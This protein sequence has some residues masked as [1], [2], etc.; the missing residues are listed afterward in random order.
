MLC[1]HRTQ[2]CR[3][4]HSL[5]TSSHVEQ[6][7]WFTGPAF[8]ARDTF[9]QPEAFELIDPEA[10]VDIR[11]QIQVFTTKA[12]ESELGSHRF[13]RFSSWKSLIRAVTKLVHKARFCTKG[14]TSKAD[15]LTQAKLIIIRNALHDAFAE[16][17][18]CLS[19]GEVVP[20]SSPLRKLNPIVDVDGL[21]RV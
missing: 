5:S 1:Q 18:K 8:L 12:S 4:W 6:L 3:P 9:S 14:S 15:E 20:K 7:N 16:E 13:E 2:P 11:P 19:R 21:L 10:D 17:M